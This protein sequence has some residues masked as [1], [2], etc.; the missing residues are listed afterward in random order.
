MFGDRGLATYYGTTELI[1]MEIV[2]NE[3]NACLKAVVRRILLWG[4]Q[5]KKDGFVRMGFVGEIMS[6][7]YFWT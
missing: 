7:K 3:S 5:S 2:V 6:R 4:A 1:C